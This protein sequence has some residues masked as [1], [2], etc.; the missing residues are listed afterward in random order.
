M[1]LDRYGCKV[2]L[3]D[4]SGTIYPGLAAAALGADMVEV[5]VTLSHWNYSVDDKASITPEELSQLV[6]GWKFIKSALANP[7]EKHELTDAQKAARLLFTSSLVA[8]RDLLI[9][10]TL[11][12]DDFSTR[13]P[14]M[15]IPAARVYEF[16][17]RRLRRRVPALDFFLEDDFE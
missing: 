10:D 7:V 2:G 11:T 4:H 6:D 9:G 13:K 16:V 8:S 15:G 17:G 5:H 14:G 3:S 1:L 12:I